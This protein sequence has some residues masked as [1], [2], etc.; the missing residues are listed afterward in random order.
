MRPGNGFW[1]KVENR[2]KTHCDYCGQQ[3]WVNPGGGIYCNNW[4]HDH[5]QPGRYETLK[6]ERRGNVTVM[7]TKDNV[8]EV[9][10][11]EWIRASSGSDKDD[12]GVGETAFN[13]YE[14]AEANYDAEFAA[15]AL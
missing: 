5:D 8:E 4:D 15:R 2:S 6:E 9:Y 3:L 13:A 11:L 7:L 10:R 1:K 12:G 14:E